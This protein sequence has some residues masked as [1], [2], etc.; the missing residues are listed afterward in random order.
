ME[1]L[2][3]IID[4]QAIPKQD[5]EL[6]L[7]KEHD[8]KIFD[9]LP[10]DSNGFHTIEDIGYSFIMGNVIVQYTAGTLF[11]H[12]LQ[13]MDTKGKHPPTISTLIE[14]SYFGFR[15][16]NKLQ[17]ILKA[18]N[19][20]SVFKEKFPYDTIDANPPPPS[21][22][23]AKQ[24]PIPTPVKNRFTHN[25]GPSKTPPLGTSSHDQSLPPLMRK[26]QDK[27]NPAKNM[28][29]HEPAPAKPAPIKPTFTKHHKNSIFANHEPAP[30]KPAPIEMSS[31]AQPLP[32][33]MPKLQDKPMPK[34]EETLHEL[35]SKIEESDIEVTEPPPIYPD[36]DD[37][38]LFDIMKNC[39]HFIH[40]FMLKN[41]DDKQF[42]Q[43]RT[44]ASLLGFKNLPPIDGIT[45]E[46]QYSMYIEDA[47]HQLYCY[48]IDVLMNYRNL[49]TFINSEYRVSK[50]VFSTNLNTANR[51]KQVTYI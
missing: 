21:S 11:Y 46:I 27:P 30:A 44:N 17:K 48:I 2:G 14:K 19:N 6:W 37:D 7:R 26:R 24:S 36:W 40:R 22:K 18:R 25:T 23:K 29:T 13:R 15:A 3:I 47:F 8:F 43:N 45:R 39:F 1:N 10:P 35:L 20:A 42:L 33:Q 5:V 38:G 41:R 12:A 9:F 28:L 31:H 16:I 51:N 34:N 32:S 49:K 50:G 4:N